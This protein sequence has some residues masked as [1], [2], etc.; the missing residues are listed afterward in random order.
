[1]DFFVLDTQGNLNDSSLCLVDDPPVGMGM[2][3]YCLA[4]GVK[5][6]PHY[7]DNAKV[8]LRTEH[9]GLKLPGILG[10]LNGYFI[11]SSK[12]KEI[13]EQHCPDEEIEFLPFALYN[14][15]KKLHSSDYWFINPIGGFDS[16]NEPACGI[17]YD[18]K[19]T[20]VTM[21]AIVLAAKKLDKAPDL[22]R[23]L[24]APQEY[25]VSRRLAQAFKDGGVSNVQGKKLRVQ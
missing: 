10:N 5:A 25:V 23:I 21:E 3:D 20:V 24:K 19:G 11:G 7:P 16:L 8:F 14:Q 18:A 4:R 15:K 9:P 17:K 12:A 13:V 2:H 22:F 1:M 6:K